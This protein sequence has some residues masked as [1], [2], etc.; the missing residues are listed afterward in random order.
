MVQMLPKERRVEQGA[1]LPVHDETHFGRELCRSEYS[2]ARLFE[3]R[4]MVQY[5]TPRMQVGESARLSVLVA[6]RHVERTYFCGCW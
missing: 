5:E 1:K 3:L 6:I 4:L 2:W